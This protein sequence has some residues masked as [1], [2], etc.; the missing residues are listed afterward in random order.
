MSRMLTDSRKKVSTD[1]S[2][3]NPFLNHEVESRLYAFESQQRVP[4]DGQTHH[5]E[6]FPIYLPVNNIS[7]ITSDFHVE[8]EID[9]LLKNM[10]SEKAVLK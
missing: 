4:L 7:E 8:N 10:D 9:T 1:E 2:K 3:T 5:I 6:H